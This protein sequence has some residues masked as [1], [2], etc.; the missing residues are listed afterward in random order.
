MRT[1]FEIIKVNVQVSPMDKAE[2]T[3]LNKRDIQRKEKSSCRS[4]CSLADRD[5]TLAN[6]DS[7]RKTVPP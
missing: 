3:D 6:L 7:E 1:G 5:L 4:C 2:R